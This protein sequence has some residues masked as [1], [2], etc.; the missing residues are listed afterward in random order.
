MSMLPLYMAIKQDEY[1]DKLKERLSSKFI[2]GNKDQ[3]WL[4]TAA[5]DRGYGKFKIKTIKG[6]RLINCA[7]AYWLIFKGPIDYGLEVCHTCDNGLCVNPHHL[8]LGTHDVNLM[9]MQDKGRRRGRFSGYTSCINGHEF[10]PLNTFYRPDGKRGCRT[11]REIR[12]DIF[13]KKRK[14]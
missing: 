8:F 12:R 2:K 14:D 7:R 13:N 10:S 11:C 1:R 3:C 6:W 4:W 5:S 9:D